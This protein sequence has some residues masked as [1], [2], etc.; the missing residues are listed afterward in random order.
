MTKCENLVKQ[1]PIRPNIG[2]DCEIA[3]L[4]SFGSRPLMIKVIFFK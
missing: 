1:N 3:V 4:C 2:F